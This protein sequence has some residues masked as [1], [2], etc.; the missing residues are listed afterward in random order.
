V[1]I[2][3][4]SGTTVISPPPEV[5]TGPSWKNMRTPAGFSDAPSVV[6]SAWGI[7]LR[8]LALKVKTCDTELYPA[9]LV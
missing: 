7:R 9:P 8:T 3:T 1:N 4:P 6:P 5:G 2:P